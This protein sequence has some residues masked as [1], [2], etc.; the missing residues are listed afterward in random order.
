[1]GILEFDVH[2]DYVPPPPFDTKFDPDYTGKMDAR[3]FEDNPEINPGM[4]PRDL[5]HII[6]L[7]DGE[8]AFT[9]KHIGDLFSYLKELNIYDKTLIVLTAD[10]GDEF[11]EHGKKGHRRS[12][13]DEVLNVPLIFK[14]PYGVKQNTKV[15]QVVSIIDIM[16]TI[17]GYLGIEPHNEIQGRNLLF[18]INGWDKLND[19]LVYARLEY[20]L[21]AA[22]SRHS[23]LI[24]HFNDVENE[25][26][27]M[28]NDPQEKV[29]LLEKASIDDLPES[30]EHMVSLLNWL[31][32]QREV[33]QTLPQT[34]GNK[35]IE[36]SQG[37]KEQL[38][39]LGYIQ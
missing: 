28:I 14:F 19:P 34:D 10:H 33:S 7:Y 31:N 21:V 24:H 38:K 26:Y 4:N 17:I 9:D 1:M 23:K 39:A 30:E 37:M 13:Y 32:A 36:L 29:N 12:L 20:K 18:S 3:G 22:R 16:P 25:F 8:I 2:Y 5:F 11:F 27:D 6:S 35:K 15:E